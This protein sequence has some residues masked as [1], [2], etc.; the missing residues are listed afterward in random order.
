MHLYAL[1]LPCL[2]P[3]GIGFRSRENEAPLEAGMMVTDGRPL[4][5]CLKCIFSCSVT[6]YFYTQ[7]LWEFRIRPMNLIWWHLPFRVL[8]DCQKNLEKLHNFIVSI[9]MPEQFLSLWHWV[10]LIDNVAVFFLFVFFFVSLEPG[11][12][13]DGA[14]GIRIENVLLVKPVELQVKNTSK[15]EK[16]SIVI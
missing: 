8:T 13:E 1:M 12:Y 15:L 5:F 9:P 14:F 2:G 7:L 11:Y 16:R 10:P 4:I 6:K 3:Q